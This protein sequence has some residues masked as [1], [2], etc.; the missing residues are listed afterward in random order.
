[1]TSLIPVVVILVNRRGRAFRGGVLGWED[2]LYVVGMHM[3]G[4]EGAVVSYWGFCGRW[5]C[6][7]ILGGL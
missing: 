5:S 4:K 1:M 3:E 2:Q 7:N 6:S